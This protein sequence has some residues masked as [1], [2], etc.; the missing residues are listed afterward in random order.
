MEWA[1]EGHNV[2]VYDWILSFVLWGTGKTGLICLCISVCVD[3]PH[4]PNTLKKL[5]TEVEN[6]KPSQMSVLVFP[7]LT[8]KR[9]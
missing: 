3:V 7:I 8:K 6:V 4:I 1:K 9:E 2:M 5:S